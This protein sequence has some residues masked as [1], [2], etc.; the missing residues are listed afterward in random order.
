MVNDLVTQAKSENINYAQFAKQYEDLE[1]A[2]N[3]SIAKSQSSLASEQAK[4]DG[5]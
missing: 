5:K 4:K 2:L 1:T 3:N